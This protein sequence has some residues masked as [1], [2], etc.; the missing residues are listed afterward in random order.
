MTEL[1]LCS[2]RTTDKMERFNAK[3]T[4]TFSE[5]YSECFAS[6]SQYAAQIYRDTEVQGSDVVHDIFIN[7]WHNKN[8]A[9]SRLS[10]LKAY[11][12]ISVRNSHK[13][14]IAK[15]VSVSKY[16]ADVMQDDDYYLSE[17]VESEA[18]STIRTML[19]ILPKDCAQIIKLYLDGWDMKE[20]AEHMKMSKSTVYEKRQKSIDLLK[21]KLPDLYTLLLL[22]MG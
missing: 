6:L 8:T 16:Q 5:V 13:N 22:L 10:E 19:S 1:N 14:Y 9:F 4:S 12:Y 15:Q 11:I 20:I 17:M 21:K 3:D 18:I 7:L 2:K